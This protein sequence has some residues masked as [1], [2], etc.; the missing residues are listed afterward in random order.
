MQTE[1]LVENKAGLVKPSP[2]GF[3]AP[4]GHLH[5]EHLQ[6]HVPVSS[7]I[8]ANVRE[9]MGELTNHEAIRLP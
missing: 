9:R 4:A 7:Y 6:S 2:A 8:S 3:N 1:G 5:T